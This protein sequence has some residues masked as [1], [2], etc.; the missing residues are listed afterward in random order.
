MSIRKNYKKFIDKEFRR[1]FGNY[2]E[3]P[4]IFYW[5]DEWK[6]YY[7]K[8]HEII[9]KKLD[10][11][12]AGLDKESQEIIDLVYRRYVFLN[13]CFN[14]KQDILINFDKLFTLSELREQN[15]LNELRNNKDRFSSLLNKALN[16]KNYLL[17][18]EH[19]FP[20]SIYK[21]DG[22]LSFLDKNILNSIKNKAII[23]GGA[24]IGDSALLFLKYSPSK[25][26]CFEPTN[27]NFNLL[28]KTIKI[29]SLGQV[30]IP[31][32]IGISNVNCKSKIY[33]E[34][35]GATLLTDKFKCSEDIELTT[36]DKFVSE[37]NINPGL[38][39]LDIEGNELE[40]I[41]GAIETI[42]KFKP[43]LLISV[44]HHA[45]D[46]FEIKPLI[47]NLNIGYKFMVRKIEPFHTTVET[48]LIGWVG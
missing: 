10:M 42:K 45:K 27:L 13:P 37:S 17:P 6:N 3:L 46:F 24:F 12:K 19:K 8:N 31:V 7:I 26:F 32:K 15:E 1:I 40:A 9:D 47:E 14:H 23:D 21:S 39:K 34:G 33:G 20:D 2:Q 16:G 48:I 28:N 36:I 18:D 44:Y 22:G 5:S 35:P 29:N 30:L 11:L 4:P 25:I 41:E 38:I 43:I